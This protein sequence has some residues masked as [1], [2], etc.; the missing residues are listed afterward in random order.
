[1]VLDWF[2]EQPTKYQY[3][4][5]VNCAIEWK[6]RLQHYCG[7]GLDCKV[8]KLVGNTQ[9]NQGFFKHW[10]IEPFCSSTNFLRNK[11]SLTYHLL[12]TGSTFLS[13]AC[14]VRNHNCS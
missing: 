4:K 6:W 11:H 1:M 12:M 5:K 9:E 14:C 10:N 8:K 3:K 7:L 13:A 2:L